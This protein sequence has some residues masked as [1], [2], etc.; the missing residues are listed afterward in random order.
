ML[1]IFSEF[2]TDERKETEGITVDLGGGASL[3]VARRDNDNYLKLVQEEADAFAIRSQGLSA[4]AYEKA[5]K[6]ILIKIL[7][8]TILLGWKNLSYKGKQL[9]YNTENAVMI[10][11]HKDFR[12][13]VME[14][15]S[16]IANYKVELEDRDEKN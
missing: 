6:D 10:L 15:A 16:D 4:E 5:D 3:L 12:K 7:A 14:H 9:E 2:A 8:G 1:D 11:S 13:M